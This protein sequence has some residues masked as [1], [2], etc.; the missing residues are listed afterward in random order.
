[1]FKELCH[2]KNNLSIECYKLSWTIL[3]VQ[4]KEFGNYKQKQDINPDHQPLAA[5]PF[6]LPSESM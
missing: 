3:E 4:K 2:G 1:M 6:D 5:L